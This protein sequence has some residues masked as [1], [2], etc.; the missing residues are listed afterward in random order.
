MQFN[1]FNLFVNLLGNG[2]KS[3]RVNCDNT[4]FSSCNHLGFNVTKP[5]LQGLNS[6]VSFCYDGNLYSLLPVQT[7]NM[8]CSGNIKKVHIKDAILSLF[9][10]NFDDQLSPNVH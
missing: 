3:R 9:S 10:C 2:T 6:R 8:T 4:S 5:K 1:D 7:G